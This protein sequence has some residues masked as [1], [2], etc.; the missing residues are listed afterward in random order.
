MPYKDPEKNR[1]CKRRWAKQ[2][3]DYYKNYLKRW[4][5]E[6][7]DKMKVYYDTSYWKDKRVGYSQKHKINNPEKNRARIIA[8]RAYTSG[9]IERQP[10]EHCGI[11][12]SEAHHPDYSKP[13][14]VKWLC[15]KCHVQLHKNMSLLTRV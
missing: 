3:P 6:N 7:A 12:K 11:E 13:L 8:Y 14:E 9:K 5:K 4:N 1:E 2:N 10:C 15:K